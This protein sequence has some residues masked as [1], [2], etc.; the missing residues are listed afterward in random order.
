MVFSKSE[1][2]PQITL[3]LTNDLKMGAH[4]RKLADE[5]SARK[6]FEKAMELP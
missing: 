3:I 6:E 5:N 1:K 4:S 2:S